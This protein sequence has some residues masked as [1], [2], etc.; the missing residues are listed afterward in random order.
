MFTLVTDKS[1]FYRIKGGQ[2]AASVE[3]ALCVPVAEEAFAG[4]IIPVPSVRFTIYTAEVG[5]TY[6]RVAEKFSV[7]ESELKTLNGNL[8]VYPTARIFVPCPNPRADAY[9]KP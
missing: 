8:P 4:R 6:K 7:E 9:N 5:D 3:S 2:S 1:R